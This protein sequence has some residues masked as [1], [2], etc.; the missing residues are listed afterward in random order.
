MILKFVIV[1]RLSSLIYRSSWT[2]NNNSQ[3]FQDIGNLFIKVPGHPIPI[4]IR[5]MT[6]IAYSD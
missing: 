3:Y 4:H 1:L 6:L 5:S 2:T